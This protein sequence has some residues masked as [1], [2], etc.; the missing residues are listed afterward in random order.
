MKIC[1]LQMII[2]ETAA[3]ALTGL[4]HSISTGLYVSYTLF[5][6]I[7]ATFKNSYF[8]HTNTDQVGYDLATE[9]ARQH[10]KECAA[11]VGDLCL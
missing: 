11:L 4:D 5:R 1:V 7:S 9:S 2:V 8:Q 3:H 10:Y 6:F